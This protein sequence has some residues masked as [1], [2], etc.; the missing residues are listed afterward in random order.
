MHKRFFFSLILIFFSIFF[1]FSLGWTLDK[2]DV[3]QQSVHP[4]LSAMQKD[5]VTGC[6][7][8][9]LDAACVFADLNDDTFMDFKLRGVG[10]FEQ[11]VVIGNAPEPNARLHIEDGNIML[12]SSKENYLIFQH[13]GL[14]NRPKF[15]VGQLTEAGIGE[16]EI[17]VLF[18]DDQTPETKVFGIEA[19]GT[20]ASVKRDYGSHFEGFLEGEK[21]PLFRLN[22][23]PTMRLELGDGGEEPPNVMF[24][25]NEEP[26]SFAL[27]VGE[28]EKLTATEKETVMNAGGNNIDF[29]IKGEGEDNLFFVSA[30]EKKIGIGSGAP[31]ATLHIKSL[32]QDRPVLI[33]EGTTGSGLKVDESGDLILPT[34]Q[35]STRPAA[36]KPG[37]MIFNSD[38]RNVNIDTG[39]E[40]ILPDGKKS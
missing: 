9:A 29:R 38:N 7:T 39:S 35:R 1:A 10:F 4:T 20:I 18:V 22:S 3:P 8:T 36:G 13:T 27:A 34:Y 5:P 32:A 24:R 26:G 40:W 14:K 31:E 6:S 28:V 15:E 16:A 33:V 19:T 30:S 23:Y 12:H 37:R 21:E 2:E 11:G 17:R 25:R